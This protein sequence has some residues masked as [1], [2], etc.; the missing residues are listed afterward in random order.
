MFLFFFL[1]LFKYEIVNSEEIKDFPYKKGSYLVCANGKAVPP[2][3]FGY[4]RSNPFDPLN[5]INPSGNG[6]EGGAN[7]II[8]RA[9]NTEY[10]SPW[11]NG[12]RVELKYDFWITSEVIIGKEPKRYS[13]EEKKIIMKKFLDG[14]RIP[15]SYKSTFIGIDQA[16]RYPTRWIYK[17]KNSENK[18][19]TI[20]RRYER[21]PDLIDNR[22]NYFDTKIPLF[23][24]MLYCKNDYMVLRVVD[25]INFVRG[26]VTNEYNEN[27]EL[28][29]IFMRTEI[30]VKGQSP[31]MKKNYNYEF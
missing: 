19:I 1:S 31:N 25:E 20:K 14:E 18:E 15:T 3:I 28:P 17:F 12:K 29:I 8:T 7:S 21:S 4:V 6:W 16:G 5:P 13:K 2:S 11:K 30:G 23:L 9:Y 22:G 24:A 26:Q 10:Y 27:I